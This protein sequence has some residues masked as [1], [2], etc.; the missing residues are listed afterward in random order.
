MRINRNNVPEISGHPKTRQ[1]QLLLEIIRETP[2]HLDAKSLYKLALE[3]DYSISPATVYRTL[4]LFKKMGLIDEKHL[5]RSCCCYEL[6]RSIQHQHLV[7]SKCGKVIEF[8]CPLNE[9][10]EKVKKEQGF[11]VTRAE[12][13]LEGLCADCAAQSGSEIAE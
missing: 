12:I 8:E 5:G 2:G 9:T 1:R 11:V 13:Y 10:V 6:K 7:C 4:N 3:R